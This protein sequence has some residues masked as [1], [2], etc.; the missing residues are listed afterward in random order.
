MKRRQAGLAILI[1]LAA[2]LVAVPALAGC[3]GKTEGK[4]NTIL[5][6]I[7]ADFTGTAGTA[8]Q[9][10]IAA[11]EEYL[12]KV[13]PNS[14]NPFEGVKV[15]FTRFDTQLDYSK[16]TGGYEELKS[17]GVDM[18]IIMNAQDKEL[19][20]DRPEEDGIP[21]IGTMG[22]QSMLADEWSI[23]TW[24]PIQ[25]QGEVEMLFIMDDWDYEGTGR[26][27]RVGHVGYTLVSSTYYQEGI[28]K[29]RNAYPD[30]F[31]WVG[32]ERGALGN[33][34][35]NAEVGRLKNC[36]Y[37][38]VSTAGAMVSSFV[39]Q[40][41]FGGYTGKFITGMEGFP[42]FWP[43]VV[44][45]MAGS[46]DK[47]Y[48]CYYVSWWPWWDED[49]PIIQECKD[50]INKYHA[51]DADLLLH[52]SAVISGFELG[53]AIEMA[54]R[55]AVDTVGAENVSRA[56]LKDGLFSIDVQLDGYINRWQTSK[57]CS[58]ALQWKQRAFVYNLSEDKFVPLATVYDPVLTRPAC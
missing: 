41:R 35:W 28:N 15:R 53:K 2:L 7:M 34:V 30:K 9:P 46:L 54:I 3:G 24:S 42:G 58:N 26:S 17:R 13:V 11:C 22:L 38:I 37:I 50:Y 56:A 10:T 6:G 16:V 4:A 12:T 39:R 29:V 52:S 47:L 43:L 1:L 32:F 31:E 40:A 25:T 55:Y 23:T 48:G 51:A 18:M 33:V 14:D 19:L 57:G 8:M 5:L 36:D 44:S 21:V 45:E 49:V 27:P 20:G